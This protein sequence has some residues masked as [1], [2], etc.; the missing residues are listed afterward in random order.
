MHT[1]IVLEFFSRLYSLA[2]LNRMSTH[3]TVGGGRCFGKASCRFA[4]PGVLIL[5]DRPS[6]ERDSDV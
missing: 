1:P 4:P 6:F 5:H 3:E 2:Q